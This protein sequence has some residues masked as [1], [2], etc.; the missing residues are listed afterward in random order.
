[1]LEGF[2]KHKE[3]EKQIYYCCVNIKTH[4]CNA[5]IKVSNVTSETTSINSHSKSCK[6]AK[7]REQD[8]G[9]NLLNKK[10]KNS[11]DVN[12]GEIPV[13][14]I[15]EINLINP[16]L[17]VLDNIS[18]LFSMN[19]ENISKEEFTN[20]FK[21]TNKLFAVKVGT[22]YVAAALF[23]IRKMYNILD[24]MY[25]VSDKKDMYYGSDLMNIAKFLK[26]ENSLDGIV[27]LASENALG[28]YKSNKFKECSKFEKLYLPS[29][30][31]ESTGAVYMKSGNLNTTLWRKQ[32]INNNQ[33][34]EDESFPETDDS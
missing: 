4:S 20:S 14:Y 32:L 26:K 10:R 12:S 29:I 7:K 17:E 6:L 25:M 22:E 8:K 30:I 19:F 3:D 31:G 13:R 24:I 33:E 18:S 28:F 21:V 15:V 34:F 1:M 27:V 9:A 5:K 2:R 23:K 11:D 16:N